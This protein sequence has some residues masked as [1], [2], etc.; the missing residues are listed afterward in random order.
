M[1]TIIVW[2]VSPATRDL[3]SAIDD[4]YQLWILVALE[5][6]YLVFLIGWK[7]VITDIPTHVQK[8]SELRAEKGFIDID[9]LET[10]EDVLE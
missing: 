1:N 7:E 4:D 8:I 5:H 2:V 3:V 6:F 9:K 10:Y